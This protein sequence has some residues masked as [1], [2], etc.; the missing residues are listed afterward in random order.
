MI[1][2]FGIIGA[3]VGLVVNSILIDIFDSTEESDTVDDQDKENNG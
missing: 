3:V 1:K 2:F